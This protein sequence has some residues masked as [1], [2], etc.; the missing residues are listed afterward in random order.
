MIDSDQSLPWER[1]ERQ[2]HAIDFPA[3]ADLAAAVATAADLCLRPERHAVVVPEA[4]ASDPDEL[5]VRI[6][7]RSPEGARQPERDLD[8]EVYR[9]GSD[10]HVMLSW[11]AAPERPM[12]WHGRHP[13]WMDGASGQRCERPED[14]PPLEALARRLRA[15]LIS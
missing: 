1:S 15:L 9:S 8:L 11:S 14:G 2:P 3:M 10:L 6:E 12:L 7:V 5:C 13:V 4:S